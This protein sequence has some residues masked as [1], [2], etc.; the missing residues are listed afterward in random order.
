MVNEDRRKDNAT[1]KAI[2]EALKLEA[3]HAH[4]IAPRHLPDAPVAAGIV[5]HLLFV[6][7]DRRSPSDDAKDDAEQ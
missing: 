3:E 5:D 7:I 4:E 1:A 6:G 2:S